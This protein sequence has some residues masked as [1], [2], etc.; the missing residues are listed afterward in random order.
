VGI[1]INRKP[2]TLGTLDKG[3]KGEPWCVAL[4]AETPESEHRIR[5]I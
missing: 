2:F 1:L 4:K 3:R 5:W